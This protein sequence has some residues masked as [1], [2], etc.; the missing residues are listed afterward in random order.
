VKL[1][2]T[3]NRFAPRGKEQFSS[4]R[5]VIVIWAVPDAA[6]QG[7][8][9]KSH[10]FPGD[11]ANCQPVDE[12]PSGGWMLSGWCLDFFLRAGGHWRMIR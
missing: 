6:P 4:C 11:P 3:H 12:R 2:A 5:L 7:W 1:A 10:A 8:M 9:L